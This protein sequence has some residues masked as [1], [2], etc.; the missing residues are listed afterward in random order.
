MSNKLRECVN[1][2]HS[3]KEVGDLLPE[4]L[5]QSMILHDGYTRIKLMMEYYMKRER[6]FIDPGRAF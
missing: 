6:A 2:L 1:K 4:Y 3:N 5:K